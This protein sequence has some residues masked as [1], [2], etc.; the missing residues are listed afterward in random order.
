MELSSWPGQVGLQGGEAPDD[1][2]EGG[3]APGGVGQDN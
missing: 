2:D 1:A 3:G